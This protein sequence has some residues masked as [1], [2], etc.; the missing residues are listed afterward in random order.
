MKKNRI[1]NGKE[2]SE[3]RQWKKKERDKR[4]IKYI[5]NNTKKIQFI[6]MPKTNNTSRKKGKKRGS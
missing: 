5:I 2:K 6:K 3:K 4:N 1:E